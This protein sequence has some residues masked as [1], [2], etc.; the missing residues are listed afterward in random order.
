MSKRRFREG[1]YGEK[2]KAPKV[3]KSKAPKVPKP[4]V[5][6]RREE[7]KKERR[8]TIKPKRLSPE[9]ASSG[10]PAYSPGY[11]RE[12]EKRGLSVYSTP[13]G[14]SKGWF[15]KLTLQSQRLVSQTP[16]VAGGSGGLKA[17]IAGLELGIAKSPG[18]ATGG[19]IYTNP[20]QGGYEGFMQ[21]EFTHILNDPYPWE[22][23]ELLNAM[24]SEQRA[25]AKEWYLAGR[26]KNIVAKA[27]YSANES[28]EIIPTL[29]EM[30]DWNP[31]N[32]P[33]NLKPFFMEM[34]MFN[35][36][37]FQLAEPAYGRTETGAVAL[38]PRID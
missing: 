27:K 25:E 30:A 3:P 36:S 22:G 23:R 19:T 20:N 1:Q 21:H 18:Q 5:I 31:A 24:T 7:A 17:G 29:L 35:P 10:R 4:T 26:E 6:S 9:E 37:A 8:P 11:F 34:G 16:I 14:T 15:N 2:F 12:M 13:S 32:L 38:P 33:E 28:S